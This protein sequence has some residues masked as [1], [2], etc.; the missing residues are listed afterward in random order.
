M[1]IAT[2]TMSNLLTSI[3]TILLGYQS[4]TLSKVKTWQRGVLGPAAMFP[5]V[6]ILPSRETYLY[7]LSN[8]KY[9]VEREVV[10][11]VYDVKMS[12]QQAKDN[13]V[14]IVKAI[15]DIFENNYTFSNSCFVSKWGFDNY[16]DTI[17]VNSGFLFVS[18]ITLRC[19][20]RESYSSMTVY[21]TVENNQS[22]VNLQGALL[23]LLKEN[24]ASHY[25]TV[26]TIVES[27]VAPIPIFPC[28]LLGAGSKTRLQEYPAATVSDIAFTISVATQLFHKETSLNHNLSIVEGVVDVL[29]QNYAINGACDYSVIDMIEYD[30]DKIPSGFIYNSIISMKSRVREYA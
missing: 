28:I 5:A 27:P 20:S 19:I 4:T 1:S 23:S 24:K 2:T 14:D 13:T 7:N 15:R 25:N 10:V 11:E 16:G 3:K 29:Q 22:V 6:A 17:K 26:E 30:Q 12:T 18:S 9:D 21:D 8:S